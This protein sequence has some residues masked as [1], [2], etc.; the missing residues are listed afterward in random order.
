MDLNWDIR[1]PAMTAKEHLDNHQVA[2]VVG[3]DTLPVAGMSI[4][5][6]GDK[7]FDV[8]PDIRKIVGQ[9]KVGAGDNQ[10]GVAANIGQG[11]ADLDNLAV[12]NFGLGPGNLHEFVGVS[13]SVVMEV[14]LLALVQSNVVV[15]KLL[16]LHPNLL[17][18]SQ[19]S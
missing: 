14:E 18:L 12:E 6:F 15:N 3:L 2:Q 10:I 17:S 16:S 4:H 1:L 13:K 5:L 11:A 9:P 8:A 7:L 19:Y